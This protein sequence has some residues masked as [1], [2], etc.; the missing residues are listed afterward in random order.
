MRTVTQ[1]LNE[2]DEFD[3][4]PLTR[5]AINGLTPGKGMRRSAQKGAFSKSVEKMPTGD[6]EGKESL[7]TFGLK[8]AKAD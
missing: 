8:R 3:D 1:L 5:L 6:F 7:K 2:I 4:L